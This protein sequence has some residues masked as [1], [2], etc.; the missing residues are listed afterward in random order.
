MKHKII[1]IDDEKDSIENLEIILTESFDNIEII[2]TTN[3]PLEGR[4]LILEKK[5]DIVLL[6]IQ[7]PQMT[8]FELLETIP[9]RNFELIFITAFNQYAIDA[10]KAD[11]VDYLLKPYNFQDVI[12][13][14]QKT[15]TK[16]EKSKVSSFEDKI[17]L[18]TSSGYEFVDVKDIVYVKADGSYCEIITK[19]KTFLVSK[20]LKNIQ[21]K[22]D[23]RIFF[24]THRTF[25]INLN[26]LKSFN[27]SENIAIMK[28]NFE[29]PVSYRIKDEFLACINSSY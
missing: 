7:M 16:I 8:G 3:N 4:R 18:K 10:F 2:A 5:P 9:E 11:A 26:Y 15:I 14:I 1:I 13:G 29:I 24:K 28:G 25:L 12:S 17:S 21:D 20:T 22:L 23:S 27:P 19:E 6:D